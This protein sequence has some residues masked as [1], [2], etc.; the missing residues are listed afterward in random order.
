MT[1][2]DDDRL[3]D[4]FELVGADAAQL[5]RVERRLGGAFDAPPRPLWQEWVELLRIRPL[6]H[7]GLAVANAALLVGLSPIAQLLAAA[8]RSLN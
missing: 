4:A 3:E 1:R 6:L 5:A 7:G 2:T 8:L